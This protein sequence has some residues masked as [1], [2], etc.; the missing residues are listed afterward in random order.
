[1]LLSAIQNTPGRELIRQ[2]LKAGFV[3]A[4]K[5]HETPSGTPQGG[6]ISPLLA[7]VALHGMEEALGVKRER[8]SGWIKNSPRAVVRYADDFV[9]MCETEEDAHQ[10]KKALHVWLNKRGLKLSENKTRIVHLDEGFDFL[11][12][13]FRRYSVQTKDS[14]KIRTFTPKHKLLI[15]PSKEAVKRFRGKIK[16]TFMMLKG[17]LP[18]V[19]IDRMNVL[20]TG[21]GNYYRPV[22]AKHTFGTLDH[23]IFQRQVRW[24]KF[25]HHRGGIGYA[26]TTLEGSRPSVTITGSLATRTQAN[27]CVASPGL[28]SKGMSLSKAHPRWMTPVSAITGL[29]VR[30]DYSTTWVGMK[31]WQ[32]AKTIHARYAKLPSLIT[33]KFI[34]I[35]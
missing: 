15:K 1:M 13:N 6:I 27:I 22:S 8:W 20:M 11:G 14:K 12:F 31:P 25:R 7:N 18:S 33:R 10:A 28:R 24:T 3:E 35:T 17:A 16:E 2:W 19:L 4:G 26:T 30:E 5:H 21:W 23:Y 34:C 29:N 9:I 32:N